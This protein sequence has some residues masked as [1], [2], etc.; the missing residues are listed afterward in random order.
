MESLLTQTLI[1]YVIRTNKIPFL[2]SLPAWPLMVMSGAI[3]AVGCAIPVTP[4][5]EYLGFTPLP[6]LYWPL[7]AASLLGYLVLTQGV[8]MWLRRMAWI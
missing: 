4:L 1:I 7:L 3:M 8:K 6:W 2:Q 5:G